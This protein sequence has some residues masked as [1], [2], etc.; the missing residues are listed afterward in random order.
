MPP[1]P[2]LAFSLSL[3]RLIQPFATLISALL[4]SGASYHVS[5]LGIQLVVSV[6]VYR[7]DSAYFGVFNVLKNA[8]VYS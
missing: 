5:Y 2:V 8:A 7:L 4:T 3:S 6:W 1:Q